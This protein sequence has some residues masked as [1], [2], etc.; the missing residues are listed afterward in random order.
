[1]DSRNRPVKGRNS[2]NE[3]ATKKPANQAGNGRGASQETSPQKTPETVTR[4]PILGL[5]SQIENQ[6]EQPETEIYSDEA[7]SLEQPTINQP[8]TGPEK[9]AQ[10][11]ATASTRKLAKKEA[12]QTALIFLSLLDGIATMTLGPAARM[13]DYEKELIREPLERIIQRM[14]IVSSELISKW[15]DPVLFVMGMVAWMSRV[16]REMNEKEQ[17]SK[18]PQP[19]AENPQTPAPTASQNLPD[20]IIQEQTAVP[21]KFIEGFTE[22]GI[23]L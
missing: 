2:V 6:D 13:L 16:I 8:E 20:V 4:A 22:T 23:K 19:Q 15:S 17:A 5:A 14:D 9:S 12:A 7:I 1:M 21:H 3:E 11:R 10:W 18:P